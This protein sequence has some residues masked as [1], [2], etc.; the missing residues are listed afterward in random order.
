MTTSRSLFTFPESSLTVLLRTPTMFCFLAGV[1]EGVFFD[2][3][4]YNCTE[5]SFSAMQELMT[6]R[7]APTSVSIISSASTIMERYTLSIFLLCIHELEFPF[8]SAN[9]PRK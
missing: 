4:L 8:S 9:V 1:P 7:T 5:A 6:Q 3:F 2:C